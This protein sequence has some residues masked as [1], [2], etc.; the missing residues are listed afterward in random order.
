MN[1]VS[2]GIEGFWS[3]VYIPKAVNILKLVT[4]GALQENV[5]LE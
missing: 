1:V 5:N 4:P 2:H 3:P